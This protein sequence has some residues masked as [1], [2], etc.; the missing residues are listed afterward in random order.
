M[1]FIVDRNVQRWRLIGL[2]FDRTFASTTGNRIEQ[3]CHDLIITTFKC[4]S[5]SMH[6]HVV[7][8]IE[9]FLSLP[10]EIGLHQLLRCCVIVFSLTLTNI[11][12]LRQL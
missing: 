5:N 10:S 7:H 11:V 6:T 3:M 4:F 2:L 1:A 9:K 8:L 12:L